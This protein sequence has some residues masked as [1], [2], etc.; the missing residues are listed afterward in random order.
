MGYLEL[1]SPEDRSILE[2]VLLGKSESTKRVVEKHVARFLLRTGK[3]LKEVSVADVASYLGGALRGKVE[4]GRLLLTYLEQALRVAGRGDVADELRRLKRSA[5]VREA[6]RRRAM[7][8]GEEL[9]RVL[10]VLWR[11][12]ERMTPRG[13]SALAFLVMLYTGFRLNE[14]L[15]LKVSRVAPRVVEARAKGGKSVYKPIEDE[16]LWRLIQS[17]A[18]ARNGSVVLVAPQTA[19]KWFKV[20]LREAGLPEERVQV[21]RPHD[22]RRTA[23]WSIYRSTGDL[24]LVQEFLHHER[25]ETTLIYLG[26][27]IAAL[28]EEEYRRA[29]KTLAEALKQAEAS[30]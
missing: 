18:E 15:R 13:D 10:E 4:A 12:A 23:A 9:R 19:W 27:G 11:E 8:S 30:R 14:A 3:A 6:E 20:F 25:P 21:I 2:V 1:L 29:A 26:K 16:R 24:K 17:R 22:L 28:E 7:L 5:R